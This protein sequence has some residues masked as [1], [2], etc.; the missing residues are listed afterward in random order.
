MVMS[1]ISCWWSPP[2]SLT[3][4]RPEDVHPHRHQAGATDDA[5]QAVS[6]YNRGHF[7]VRNP[8]WWDPGCQWFYQCGGRGEPAG[9]RLADLSGQYD[10]LA[11]TNLWI[12]YYY[13]P[14]PNGGDTNVLMLIPMTGAL[15]C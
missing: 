15:G 11:A 4:L 1:G 10:H 14:D 2:Y 5:R 6:H 13:S 7:G 12:R 9:E 8:F 3:S